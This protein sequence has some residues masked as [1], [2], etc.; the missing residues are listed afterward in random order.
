MKPFLQITGMGVPAFEEYD[1]AIH[2]WGAF[3]SPN[4][5][6]TAIAPAFLVGIDT[7]VKDAR[8]SFAEM[9]KMGV[10]AAR[11]EGVE[12]WWG[13]NLAGLLASCVAAGV[14]V[15][16]VRGRIE[17]GD[18]HGMIVEFGECGKRYHDWWIVPRIS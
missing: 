13:K 1:D 5:N 6:L 7:M 2:P 12:G 11:C 17:K 14:G 15:A 3:N 8:T 9:K 18:V 4:L 16:G 10:V